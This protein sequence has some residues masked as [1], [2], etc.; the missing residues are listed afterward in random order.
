MGI[1]VIIPLCGRGQRFVDEGYTLPKPC[2]R[3]FDKAILQYALDS[4]KGCKLYIFTNIEDV[5]QKQIAEA[6][7]TITI[8]SIDRPTI[9]AADTVYA[10]LQMTTIRGK[11]L[12]ADGDAFYTEDIINRLGD[13]N[14][15]ISF[16]TENEA[17]VYSYVDTDESAKILK[18]REKEKISNLAN[19]GAYFFRDVCELTTY[20][21]YVLDNKIHF[22]GE[23]YI[24][25]VIQCMLDKNEVFECIEIPKDSFICLGTPRHVR[26]Y[27]QRTSA[28][29]FDLDGTLVKTDDIYFSVWKDILKQYS[30]H[31]TL[32]IYN[33]Y[34]YSNSDD[35]VIKSLLQNTECDV[36][37]I[38]Q[39][40][41]DMFLERISS[42]K[43]IDGAVDF[44]LSRKAVG[45]KVAIVT[46]C[47][48]STAE[49]ILKQMGI[50]SSIDVIVV[51]SECRR[52]KPHPDPYEEA[53]RFF[54]IPNNQ[55]IVLEDSKNGILSGKSVCP[56]CIIGIGDIE[57]HEMLHT[58]G[59]T[60]T[61]V[62]FK[63]I[64]ISNSS[65]GKSGINIPQCLA[66]IFPGE[67][68]TVSPVKLKGGFISDVIGVSVN[69]LKLILKI[70]NSNDTPLNQMANNLDLYQRE[71]LFYQ[72]FSSLVPI[73]VP[74]FYGKVYDPD[75]RCVG[76]L[77]EDMRKNN[78]TLNI[79]LNTAPVEASLSVVES[80]AKL[81]ARFWN[82]NLVSKFNGL[83]RNNTQ[84]FNWPKFITERASAF[85][86]KWSLLLSKDDM[87]IVDTIVSKFTDIQTE[88][89]QGHLTLCHG[90]VKSPN[91]F[92]TIENGVYKPY[93]LD[94]Q[95]I[96]EGKGVQDLVFFMIESFS[97]ETLPMY[98]PLLKNYYY[99]KLR[100]YGVKNY[101]Y[102][103]YSKDLV[104]ASY[105]FP[106]FVAIWFGTT[107]EDDLI[108]I[109]FPF[110]FIQKLF[111]FYT[112]I[113]T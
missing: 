110:F 33:T 11:C 58:Y 25:C 26:E 72:S 57:V 62:D 73:N 104:T 35:M 93:F 100:E 4:F 108:D 13:K 69:E 55:C 81:H 97:P 113:S 112:L 107:A 91:I 64:D 78:F 95:Y 75:Y 18:I 5:Y 3:V 50:Y 52:P 102:N 111:G 65:D 39:I 7:P 12:L 79:D 87:S 67:S 82:K 2:I 28:W 42:I 16:R 99:T 96:V 98:F 49:S 8:V 9:G 10:G 90:D 80:I 6:N 40:K 71:Y 84:G 60:Y 61:Y 68:I 41:N 22:R 101:S 15:V 46:N 34:I 89:S 83:R 17:P 31:L 51:G 48:R 70:E 27:S 92:Y 56:R 88:L 59:A 20:C 76:I 53:I 30:L 43:I 105:Y 63:N 38:S 85:K 29:L 109:N 19:T 54:N 37:R 1:N 47:N 23:P 86:D 21:K 44:I 94:W 103:E 36:S 77:L 45:D 14:A 32:D 74:R 106:F 24:S 66:P